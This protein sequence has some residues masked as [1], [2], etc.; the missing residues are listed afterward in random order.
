VS[1]A[2]E[3]YDRTN[4]LYTDE[5]KFERIDYNFLAIHHP[6]HAFDP[7]VGGREFDACNLSASEHICRSPRHG[8]FETGSLLLMIGRGRTRRI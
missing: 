3:L 8:R 2:S 6:L 4:V 5:V 1:F 7:L